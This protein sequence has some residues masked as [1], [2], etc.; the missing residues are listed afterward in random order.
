MKNK[1]LI[2][3]QLIHNS[4]HIDLRGDFGRFFCKASAKK[5]GLNSNISQVSISNNRIKGTIRG[6]HFQLSPFSED[7]YVA[8]VKGR[9]FDVAVDLRKKSQNYLK[10]YKNILSEND[11]KVLYIPKGF[12]HGFQTLKN[13]SMIIYG[14]T[15]SYNKDYQSGIRYNDPTINIKWPIK[16]IKIS[17]KDKNLNYLK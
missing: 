3:I 1:K 16:K 17:K 13:N 12:A 14:M 5:L 15:K 11:N 2:N 10:I 8:C 9:L 6:L 7:K 4:K